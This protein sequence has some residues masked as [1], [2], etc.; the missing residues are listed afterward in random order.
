[1]F[2]ERT[3]LQFN[4]NTGSVTGYRRRM[5]KTEALGLRLDD[6]IG[7]AVEK[8]WGPPSARRV[9]IIT[10]EK[11]IPLTTEYSSGHGADDHAKKIHAWLKRNNVNV[12]L[13]LEWEAPV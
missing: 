6:I 3:S 12:P 7:L 13:A 4:A 1:M 2:T 11:I 10:A 8:I 9:V 5:R